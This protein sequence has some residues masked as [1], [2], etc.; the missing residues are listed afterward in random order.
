MIFEFLNQ[1]I[2]I[3]LANLYIIHSRIS[4]L[5]M[6]FIFSPLIAIISSAMNFF[7][8]LLFL[9]IVCFL[10]WINFSSIII[11]I[12]SK[13]WLTKSLYSGWIVWLLSSDEFGQ[14]NMRLIV[15]FKSSWLYKYLIGTWLVD[16]EIYK[17]IESI[18]LI[19][20]LLWMEWWGKEGSQLL[21][22]MLKSSVI[23]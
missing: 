1:I 17:F 20:R 18:M 12:V 23:T 9:T 22:L 8:S 11:L 19:K 16:L 5:V 2:S 4:L 21:F 3:L 15:E 14:R 10:V 7:S 13:A 6:W